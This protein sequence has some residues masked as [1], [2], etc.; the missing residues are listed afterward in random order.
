MTTVVKESTPKR[1]RTNLACD[2][3]RQRKTR[4]DGVQPVCGTCMKRKIPCKFERKYPRAQVSVQYVKTLEEKL[5]ILKSQ[6]RDKFNDNVNLN[7]N[8]N[9]STANPIEGLGID[10]SS[11]GELLHSQ[12]QNQIN[13]QNQIHYHTQYSIQQLP[14]S[15]N[16]RIT[17]QP[18]RNSGFSAM[19]VGSSNDI[20][21]PS[22]AYINSN[23]KKSLMLNY[24]DK[25]SVEYGVN[26][27]V[28]SGTYKDEETSAD[29]MG[30]GSLSDD[31]SKD[32]NFYGSSAAVSFM[33]ELALT[34]DGGPQ[35][36]DS[37]NKKFAE[38]AKYKM[39]RNDARSTKGLSDMLVPPRSIADRYIRNYFDFTYNLYPFV[40][41]PT[42]MAAYD[43]IWSA[44]AGSYEVDE[45]FYSILNIIF[46]FGCRLSLDID[47]QESFANADMYF[48]RS[49]EL[50]RFHLMDA[51]SLLLV[52]ALILTG[53]YLQATTRSAGCWNIIGLAI[54]MAQ[55][56][57]LHEEQNL[58]ST[59]SYIE[60]EMKERLWHG[61]LMMDRIVSMTLGRPMMVMHDSRMSLPSAIDDENILDDSYVPSS[62]PSYMC[63]FNETVKL[64]DILA[65]I[66]KI[67][68]SSSE[69]EFF[70]LFLSIFKIEERLHKFHENVP[71]H[72]KFGF[73]LHEKPFRRQSIILHL[74][75]LHLKM[76]LYR[77]VLFPKKYAANRREIHSELISHTTNSI[78]LLCVEAAIELIQ[79]V[80]KYRAED[81]EILPASWYTV[82]YLYS[83]ETVML[84]AKL[85]PTL[86]EETSTE[87]FTTA[88]TNGLEM[89]AGYQDES[90]S[91]VR[92]LKI[93][94]IM[95]ERVHASAFRHK[96]HI[97]IPTVGSDSAQNSPSHI[98]SDILY[99]LL[100]DTA[101]PFGGP[102]FYRE[103]MNRFSS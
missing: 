32:K 1:G 71:T 33:K 79:V 12:N 4:C 5:K 92:C 34:V 77:R 60:K 87:V 11:S 20:H 56:L 57:G 101:G 80:K 68:Y 51:G 98:P 50:L 14:N 49:Q 89:L 94:E 78:S 9:G 16:N 37:E 35:R 62:N 19:S 54:R 53:Q 31:R 72:I 102:F 38:R 28:I 100:Y 48:E 58:E 99:S 43:E 83:A 17:P 66:L 6:G 22:F 59:N 30:A 96:Q 2:R 61:C 18:I 67:F 10:S 24:D 64:Y 97:D 3:C 47:H 8:N 88:W 55:G 74:R 27:S 63:F 84:A 46:A 39:S 103:E 90:E 13:Q 41:K 21:A 85:K 91:A 23:N 73:E 42:F 29:A 75:Y 25:H 86:Q 26:G 76:V 45:L 81:I 52:Q 93:L 36:S 82:F 44:D 69:P 15:I 70:D 7:V 95:G 65:D 40:H